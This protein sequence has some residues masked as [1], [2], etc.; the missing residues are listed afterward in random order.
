M[1]GSCARD[2]R[3]R[4]SFLALHFSLKTPFSGA[5]PRR[6]L[7]CIKKPV[8]YAFSN[9]ITFQLAAGNITLPSL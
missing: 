3:L 4:F 7:H 1:G 5:S 2:A 9:L 8:F 6:A